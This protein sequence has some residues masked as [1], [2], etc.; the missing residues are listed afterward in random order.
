MAGSVCGESECRTMEVGSAKFETIPE[1]LFLRAAL[2]ASSRLL[3]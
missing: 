3:A 1:K 2:L